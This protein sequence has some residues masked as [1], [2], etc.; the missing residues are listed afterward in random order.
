LLPELVI[1]V[2]D[3]AVAEDPARLALA[4]DS[5]RGVTR[6]LIIQH[7]LKELP[8]GWAISRDAAL[9]EAMYRAYDL[10]A[11]D[12]EYGNNGAAQML[13]EGLIDTTRPA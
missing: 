5:L 3:I 1:P 4:A 7:R 2:P 13:A 6:G 11:K 8:R 10:G 9:E 12:L